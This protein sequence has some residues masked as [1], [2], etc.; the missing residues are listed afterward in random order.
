MVRWVKKDVPLQQS[1]K[2]VN[3]EHGT[4]LHHFYKPKENKVATLEAN[5]KTWKQT[6]HFHPK[7]SI[8]DEDIS[9]LQTGIVLI[10]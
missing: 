9:H 5:N 4:G 2:V 10:V 8:G 1:V 6:I 3:P 7:T